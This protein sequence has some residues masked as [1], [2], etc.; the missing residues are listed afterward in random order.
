MLSTPHF[1]QGSE[2]LVKDVEGLNPIKEEHETHF[3]LEPVR[4]KSLMVFFQIFYN[5]LFLQALSVPLF[6]SKR[7]QLNLDVRGYNLP[8]NTTVGPAVIPLYWMPDIIFPVLWL[9]EVIHA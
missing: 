1:F 2:Y 3:D 4:I 5:F 6:A 9:N 7:I 8:E